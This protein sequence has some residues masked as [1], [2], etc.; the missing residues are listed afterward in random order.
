MKPLKRKKIK[1]GVFH[2]YRPMLGMVMVFDT[3]QE[4]ERACKKQP[5]WE[6]KEIEQ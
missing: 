1:Y 4:A 2:K 5:L 6:I 3:R